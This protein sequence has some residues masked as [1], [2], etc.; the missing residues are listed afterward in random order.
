MSWVR[1]PPRQ[2]IFS[3]K[4]DCLGCAVLLCLVCLTL[5]A[6]FLLISHM[7]MYIYIQLSSHTNT[8]HTCCTLNS[9]VENWSQLEA[10]P[11]SSCS[12]WS[13]TAT[14]SAPGL[15]YNPLSSLTTSAGIAPGEHHQGNTI[16]GNTIRETPSGAR[17]MH[18]KHCT[19]HA[20]NE[21]VMF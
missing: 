6:F 10:S 2:L 15:L 14:S 20:H 4:S 7:Y 3:R 18:Y 16:R 5:L 19:V 13:P 17:Y 8:T 11:T 9:P 1:V 21:N 12:T